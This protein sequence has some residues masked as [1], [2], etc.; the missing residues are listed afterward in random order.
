MK[1]LLLQLSDIHVRLGTETILTQAERIT[2]AVRGLDHPVAAV[3]IALTG[4]IAYSGASDQYAAAGR[5]ISELCERLSAAVGPHVSV[6]VAA[7]PGNHDCVLIPP[8]PARLALIDEMTRNP[9]I[10]DDPGT[11]IVCTSVQDAFFDFRDTFAAKFLRAGGSRLY[12]E[13]TVPAGAQ[14]LLVRCLNTAWVSLLPEPPGQMAYPTNLIPQ[15][16]STPLPVVTLL[17]HP[18]NWMQPSIGRVVRQRLQQGPGIVLMGH[19]HTAGARHQWDETGS[20]SLFID[21]PALQE[22]HAVGSAFHALLLDTD[23]NAVRVIPFEWEGGRFADVPSPLSE[24]TALGQDTMRSGRQFPLKSATRA[25]LQ[26]PEIDLHAP[27]RGKLSLDDIF[28]Y[29]DLREIDQAPASHSPRVLSSRRLLEESVAHERLLVTG[30]KESG[31]TC[32]AKRTFIDSLDAG[33]VPVFVD[34]R[35]IKLGDDGSRL[36]RDMGN[37]FEELYEAERGALWDV[38]REQRVLILDNYHALPIGTAARTLALLSQL[39]GRIVLF[40]HDLTQHVQDLVSAAARRGGAPE[41]QHLHIMPY[42][43]L[44]REDMIDRFVGLARGGDA[45]AMETLRDD[46]RKLLNVALGRYYAPPVPVAIVSLLQARAFREQLDLSQSTY[47]YYYDLLVRRSLTRTTAIH[48]ES[49]VMFGY[50]TALVD[51]LHREGRKSWDETWFLRFHQEFTEEQGLRL[52]FVNVMETLVERNILLRPPE[53]PDN[54]EFRY[55]YFYFFFAA[56]ALAE[57]LTTPEGVA[58]VAE[59]TKHLDEEDAANTL[60]FL[61]HFSRDAAVIDPMLAQAERVFGE[62][63]AA[64]LE[65]DSIALPGLSS[66][67]YQA[68]YHERP[69]SESR[70]LY[71]E[72]LD[73]NPI[74][75]PPRRP[76]LA[77]GHSGRRAEYPSDSISKETSL[78]GT[79]HALPS[80]TE[81]TRDATEE[82]DARDAELADFTAYID[83][84]LSA[85]RTLQIL[86]QLLKNHPGTLKAA[87]KRRIGRVAYDVGLRL[88]SSVYE[89]ATSRTPEI[90]EDIVETIR[91]A[92]PDLSQERLQERALDAVSWYIYIASYGTIQRVAANVGTPLLAPIFEYLETETPTPA[93]RLITAAL[94]L[95]R[96][97]GFSPDRILALSVSLADNPLAR[98]VLSTLVLTHFHLFDV[99]REMKQRV[100]ARL[101]IDYRAVGPV[102]DPRLKR[103]T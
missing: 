65:K 19:E 93:V 100:C 11:A 78:V 92:H 46:L 69:V 62:F 40:S 9:A 103:I 79:G 66:T 34:A 26:D 41:V 14:T 84:M 49:D 81:T 58:R 12:Y 75:S 36:H 39:F 55:G 67:V 44:R 91:D 50:L 51:R 8:S 102:V 13:Y 77:R 85:F 4:D 73:A 48:G 33:L 15:I 2:D 70:R 89:I 99:S 64:T 86:G 17:H 72:A 56:R 96:A 53:D 16:E 88:L 32:L 82:R 87:Q 22:H 38:V 68:V 23:A 24:W 18:T 42:G 98:R 21:S 31:K 30:A 74:D 71:L 28:V 63:K 43:H 6:A 1:I 97:S 57:G 10:V 29:P 20:A 27:H 25:W 61:T 80:E 37:R 35:R 7:I 83:R 101:G 60:L 52:S 54:Y 47:G 5:W 95:D 94:E 59:L 90:V 3:L 76:S 45:A